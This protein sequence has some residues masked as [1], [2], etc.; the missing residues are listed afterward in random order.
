MK[1][2]PG[3]ERAAHVS[4]GEE[5]ETSSVR[6]LSSVCAAQSLGPWLP[7]GGAEPAHRA[8]L[9]HPEGT[10]GACR[11]C[12]R[13]LPK[14]RERLTG[15][16]GTQW[17][18]GTQTS[19]SPLAAARS[20]AHPLTSTSHVCLQPWHLSHRIFLLPG[21]L[22]LPS[23]CCTLSQRIHVDEV[24]RNSFCLNSLNLSTDGNEN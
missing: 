19:F 13:I 22:P 15:E 12:V 11:I 9:P 14:S 24:V 20:Q 5:T 4:W 17:T 23:S 10:S 7:T 1:H 6:A 8:P 16:R 3:E 2:M 21:Q 18:P